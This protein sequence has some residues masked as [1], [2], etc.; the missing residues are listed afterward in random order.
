VSLA[1]PKQPPVEQRRFL[2]AF[3]ATATNSVSPP[4]A[5]AQDLPVIL[6]SPQ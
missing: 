5:R 1:L 2:S 3:S 4:S 6:Y